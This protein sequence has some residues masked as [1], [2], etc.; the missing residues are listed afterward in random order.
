M[1]TIGL[2]ESGNE[3]GMNESEIAAASADHIRTRLDRAC[4]RMAES[5]TFLGK[6]GTNTVPVPF[7]SG[8]RG[9]PVAERGQAP[10]RST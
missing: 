6:N 2:T 4:Q 8:P 1:W 9:W 5:A 10:S 7:F 3:L